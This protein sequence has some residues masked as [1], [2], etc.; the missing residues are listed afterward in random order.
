MSTDGGG[1]GSLVSETRAPLPDFA[2]PPVIEVA[3]DVQFEPLAKLRTPELARFWMSLRERFP[4]AEEQVALPPMNIEPIEGGPEQP[5]QLQ[6]QL[7][8]APTV[9]RWWLLNEAASELVQVQQDRFIVNW[10]RAPRR[11]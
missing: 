3:L 8:R 6:L 5:L 1:D 4:R 2:R 9:D 7:L 10:R 11:G